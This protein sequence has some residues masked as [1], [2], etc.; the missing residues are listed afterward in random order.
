MSP[1]STRYIGRQTAMTGR[2]GTVHRGWLSA[3]SAAAP[4]AASSGTMLSWVVAV[5]SC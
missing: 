5:A 3:E 4:V 2:L 1:S